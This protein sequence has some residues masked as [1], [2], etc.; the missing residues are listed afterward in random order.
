VLSLCVITVIAAAWYMRVRP[1]LDPENALRE[2]E[3]YDVQRDQQLTDPLVLCGRD[4]VPLVLAG[5]AD[6]SITRRP[7]A[8]AFLGSGGYVQAIPVLTEVALDPT[9]HSHTRSS[10]LASIALLDLGQ[11]ERLQ[12]EIKRGPHFESE[13]VS[14]TGGSSASHQRSYLAALFSCGD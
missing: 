14:I 8:A 3:N 9:E 10:A 11:A 7:W 5:L 12:A 2:F 13:F 6:Q 1:F 4:V